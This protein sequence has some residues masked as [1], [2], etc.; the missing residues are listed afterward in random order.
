MFLRRLVDLVRHLRDVPRLASIVGAHSIARRMFVT[1]A[2]DGLLSALGIILGL[3]LAGVQQPLSYIGAV[4]GGTGVMGVFSGFVAT[5]LSERAERLREL[6]E[7]EKVMLR[8][9][10]GSIYDK[11][12]RLVP[13]YVASWS[14]FGA[15]VPPFASLTPFF[16]AGLLHQP[17]ALLVSESVSL[18]LAMMF[19]I[20]YYLGRVSGE[21]PWVSGAR[22][23]AIGASAS[24]LLLLLKFA[25]GAGA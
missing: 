20:G 4:M 21:N 22:F 17:V 16:A 7:T 25:L 9:L 10:E 12:A 15:V 6:H 23:L 24:A 19:L 13:L 5:Y 11:A 1:N 3:Y 18:I 14:A 2:F 8:S